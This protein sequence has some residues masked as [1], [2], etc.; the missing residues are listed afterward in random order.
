[1]IASGFMRPSLG[2]LEQSRA[3]H[4]GRTMHSSGVTPLRLE[5]YKA[6]VAV[7]AMIRA[8]GLSRVFTD[9]KR[10]DAV[11]KAVRD[12]VIAMRPGEVG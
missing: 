1:M 9:P 6:I 5:D 7:S 3:G 12:Y 10:S 11:L 2:S 8:L 4:C